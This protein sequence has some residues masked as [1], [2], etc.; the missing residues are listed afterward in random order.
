MTW[1]T[2][3]Y[4][5]ECL[6][7]IYR[8]TSEIEFEVIVLDNGSTD[9]TLNML[10]EE[11]PKVIVIRNVVNLGITQ[12][13]KGM[14]IAR[15]RFIAFVDSDIELLEPNTFERLVD[16]VNQNVDVGLV[17]PMLI[18]NDGEVQN[19]CKEFLRFYTPILRRLDFMSC[20]R[21]LRIYKKQLMADWDHKSIREVDYTVA[22]FWV[23]RRE[24]INDVGLLDE[25]FFAGPEDT[26]YCLR[27]WKAGY[28][29][30]YYPLLKAKHHYQRMSRNVFSKT[31][32]EHFKGLIYYFL[33]HGYLIKPNV[34]SLND[35]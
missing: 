26:D 18:L 11:F 32:F 13:N 28:K 23:F 19:S 10:N 5:R 31:T 34:N 15:G 1:N 6:R 21:N 4:L 20:I 12:R 8:F 22:A 33:K 3:D 17:S 30:V 2:K 27:I 25:K 7:S 16:Y 35:E 14:N 24:I 9:N 29:V